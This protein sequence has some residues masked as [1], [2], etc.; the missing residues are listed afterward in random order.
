MMISKIV[1]NLML[2]HR[3]LPRLDPDQHVSVSDEVLVIATGDN[4]QPSELQPIALHY[5]LVISRG[6]EIYR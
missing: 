6:R 1:K 2:L 5:P 3:S 4:A